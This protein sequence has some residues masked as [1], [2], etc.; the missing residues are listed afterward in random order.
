MIGLLGRRVIAWRL[1]LKKM[2]PDILAIGAGCGAI[3]AARWALERYVSTP[4]GFVVSLILGLA[5]TGVYFL[6]I[7]KNL[8]SASDRFKSA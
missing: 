8:R 4:A 1:D 6:K 5:L 2:L 7:A 3:Y